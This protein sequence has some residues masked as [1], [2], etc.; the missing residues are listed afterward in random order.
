MTFFDEYD[1]M[2]IKLLKKY[3]QMGEDPEGADLLDATNEF[4]IEHFN[5][6]DYFEK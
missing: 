6:D 2:L 5:E 1:K 4:I 3:K